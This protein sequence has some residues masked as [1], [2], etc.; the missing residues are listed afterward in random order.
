MLVLRRRLRVIGVRLR[1]LGWV[2]MI[3]IWFWDDDE[4]DF[5]FYLEV[6]SCNVNVLAGLPPTQQ[7]QRSTKLA[8]VFLHNH[9]SRP[10]TVPWHVSII[11]LDV[12]DCCSRYITN[13]HS[14]IRPF[15]P[16]YLPIARHA[17]TQP[18]PHYSYPPGSPPPQ[19]L[20]CP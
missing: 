16:P 3:M 20:V 18:N 2:G 1:L 13:I 10:L 8:R 5:D 17:P 9:I 19:D 6:Y 7:Q 4:G 15:L 12:F 14:S 11:A